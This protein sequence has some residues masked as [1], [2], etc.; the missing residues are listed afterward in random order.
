[1]NGGEEVASRRS[2]PA[3]RFLATFAPLVG[4]DGVERVFQPILVEDSAGVH[5]DGFSAL[6]SR[7]ARNLRRA[8]HQEAERVPW[9][10]A[11]LG[12]GLLRDWFP[13]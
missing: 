4:G 10:S 9:A 11:G 13:C 7:V 8:T 1:L 6:T 12:T 5:V 2:A 3:H